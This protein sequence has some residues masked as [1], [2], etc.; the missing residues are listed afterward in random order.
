MGGDEIL[1]DIYTMQTGC[2]MFQVI[3]RWVLATM[4]VLKDEKKNGTVLGFLCLNYPVNRG[5]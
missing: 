5:G 4:K 1:A 2:Q 3:I